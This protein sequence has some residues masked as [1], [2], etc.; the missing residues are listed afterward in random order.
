MSGKQSPITIDATGQAPGRLAT[1]VAKLLMG[2]HKPT[3]TPNLDEGEYVRVEHA[4]NMVIKGR[5][6]L[7]GKLYYR[8]TMYPGGLR[9]KTLKEVWEADPSDVLRRAVK[10]MM[11]KNRLH[12]E[13]MKRLTIS[14]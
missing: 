5:G 6:K 8:H 10:N 9:T 7:A 1:E 4:A 2:K 14:N 12:T 11:P 13:R 3:Y